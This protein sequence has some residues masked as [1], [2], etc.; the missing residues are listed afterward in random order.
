MLAAGDGDELRPL[1]ADDLGPGLPRHPDGRLPEPE[2]RGRRRLIR[3]FAV[4][5]LTISVLYL[6]WRLFF[7]ID[8]A[9]WFVAVPMLILEVHHALGV[10]LYTFSLWD[11]DA[12]PPPA[13]VDS[14]DLRVAVLITTHDESI[15]VLLPVVSAALAIDPPHETWVL[16]DGNRPEVAELAVG[17]GA[18]YLARESNEHAKAG[19]LNNALEHIQADVI[20]VFDADHVVM[21]EFLMNTLGYF[22]DPGIAVVQTPQDFYNVDSFEHVARRDRPTFQEQAVFYRLILPAK[23]RWKAGFWCGT[24]ALVRVSAL[25]DVGGVATGS[26]TEDIHTSIRLHKRG[27]RIVVHNEV[28][29]RGLAATNISQYMLQ[30]R[31]WARG[32]MQ[33]MRSERLLTSSELTIPQRVAYTATLWAWFDALRSLLFLGLPILVLT[34][35]ALPITAPL[36]IFGPAF[37]FTFL[38]Q[39]T[40]LRLLARGYYPPVLSVVFELL[41]MPAVI[42]ALTEVVRR[43]GPR[44]RVT[45]KGRQVGDRRRARVP[46]LVTALLIL[47][48]ESLLWFGVIMA[49]WVPVR[50]AF[51][52]AMIGTAAF[53]AMNL[54]F[55]ISATRR[56]ID[57]RFAG[58]RRA[59]VRFPVDM[60]GIFDGRIARI[61][62]MSLTGARIR[63]GDVPGIA[64]SV[65]PTVE[66]RVTFGEIDLRVRVVNVYPSEHG[67]LDLGVLFRSGQWQEVRK[68][69]LI[70]FHGNP[71]REQLAAAA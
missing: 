5:S 71:G 61:V 20:A 44:F 17:L 12:P 4:T 31:R 64:S 60:A 54:I 62:D 35:G 46:V 65:G 47:S 16:D 49:G 48:V 50:Y 67:T 58:E 24:N 27:W 15:E 57:P 52:G 40:A 32:A 34:T 59:S 14:T 63:V 45:P 2:P 41:R 36:W 3:S 8:L 39:F 10:G 55:L 11:T 26:V 19:N 21:P 29:A 42:P 7:T 68:L 28:L 51:P 30:R 6:L 23:N 66:L 25:L 18:S 1:R 69:A 9:A 33:V 56:I 43:S 53:L 22:D 70:L 37:L 13:G 38:A